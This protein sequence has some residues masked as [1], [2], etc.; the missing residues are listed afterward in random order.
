M[1]FSIAAVDPETGKAGVAISTATIVVGAQCPFVS[2]NGVV[3][4]QSFG[5]GRSYGRN[6]LGM[7]D[8]GV[9]LPTACRALLDEHEGASYTQ[10]HGID[11]EGRQ[12]TYTGEDCVDWAGDAAG[13]DCTAAGNMLA[14]PEV[15]EGLVEGYETATGSFEERLLS[16]LADGEAAGGDKRAGPEPTEA[17]TIES[18]DGRAVESAALLVYAPEPKLYHNL[19]IDMSVESIAELRELYDVTKRMSDDL[20]ERADEFWGD[21]GYPEDVIVN[22]VKY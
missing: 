15:V 22:D 5:S 10:L 17:F 16:A 1:T 4:T 13:E 19:R 3:S 21:D 7:L 2:E 8:F 12:F 18:E 6:A 9:S 14:G 20:R 11:G